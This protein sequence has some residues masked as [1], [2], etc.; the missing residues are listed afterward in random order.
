M[1][2]ETC[3]VKLDNEYFW[4]DKNGNRVDESTQNYW[5][6]KIPLCE[7]GKLS[8]FVETE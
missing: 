5:N 1:N 4:I 3:R 8:I 7:L 6:N 2:G